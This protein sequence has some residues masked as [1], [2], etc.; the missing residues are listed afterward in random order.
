MAGPKPTNVRVWPINRKEFYIEWDYKGEDG[1]TAIGFDVGFTEADGTEFTDS[2]APQTISA[3]SQSSRGEGVHLVGVPVEGQRGL[4]HRRSCGPC[5]R[6]RHRHQ[7]HS[8]GLDLPRYGCHA[9]GEDAGLPGPGAER[10]RHGGRWRVDGDVGCRS[11]RRDVRGCQVPGR[12][13]TV[14]T[15]WTGGLRTRAST[16]RSGRCARRT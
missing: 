1:T 10:H 4:P 3:G 16:T 7:V 11:Q 15:W 9:Q 6:Q 13:V 2:L 8:C 14:G 12:R 5:R